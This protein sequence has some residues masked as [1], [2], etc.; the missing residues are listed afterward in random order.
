[1]FYGERDVNMPVE[2]PGYPVPIPLRI[3]LYQATAMFS[4]VGQWLGAPEAPLNSWDQLLMAH[5]NGE[6][7]T[8]VFGLAN[9]DSHNTADLDCAD[10]DCSTVG[11]GKSGVYVKELTVKELYKAIKAGR[12]FATTG[13]SLA[14]DVN[15]E[16]MGDTAYVLDGA[17]N[18][19]LSANSESPTARH[20]CQDRHP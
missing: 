13:P 15:G 1:M 8:P 4:G 7:D 17:A 9:S 6:V 5:V 20:T 2:L 10:G 19:N 11:A 18:V 3:A 16:I 12:T 14:L